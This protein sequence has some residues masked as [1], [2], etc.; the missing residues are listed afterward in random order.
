MIAAQR[1]TEVTNERLANSDSRNDIGL[2]GIRRNHRLKRLE[3]SV[4]FVKENA[5]V[6]KASR[7]SEKF[8][9]GIQVL[10]AKNYVDNLSEEVRKG[11]REKAEQGDWPSVAPIGYVNNLATHRID[12]D[13]IRGPIV[14]QLFDR[15]AT[16]QVSLHGL[17]RGVTAAGLTL[18]R[19]GRPLLK[20]EIHRILQ[21][22]IDYG[23]FR[24]LGKLYQGSH[25]P[26]VS[27]DLFEAVQ[28]GQEMRARLTDRRWRAQSSIVATTT[29]WRAASLRNSGRGRLP[30]GKRSWGG[31]PQN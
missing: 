6:S 10:M 8:M 28:Q 16:G 12:I 31:S 21:N 25:D 23:D 30:S 14:S 17:A 18:P 7:S 20:G 29:I 2:Q 1:S 22:P 5:I 26:L 9:H 3:L 13:P 27:R 24:W 11:L 4:H 15:Y 19:S